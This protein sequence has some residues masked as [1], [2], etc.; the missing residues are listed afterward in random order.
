MSLVWS[1]LIVLGAAGI[2]IAAILLVR[3]RAPAGGYFADG[4]RAAG[5][6]GVIA[7]GFSV[8]LGL[9]VFLAFSSYDQSRTGAEEEAMAVRLQHETAEFLPPSVRTNLD[10]ELECYARYVIFTDWPRLEANAEADDSINPWSIAMATTLKRADPKTVPEQVAYDKWQD[11]TADREEA[12]RDRI[13]GAVGVIPATLWI[14]LLFIAGTIFGY[15]LLFADSAERK[16]AQAVQMGS[17]VAVLA[18][19]LLLISYL[20]NAFTTGFGGL[21]PV[22]MERTLSIIRQEAVAASEH[23]PLPCDDNGVATL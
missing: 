4:D 23:G 3:R 13:H 16:L 14:V 21:K 7:T 6:F 2:A 8:L 18:S 9:I 11:R 19:L 20:D 5:V 15:M 1:V 12:R 10:G 17:V 22:A